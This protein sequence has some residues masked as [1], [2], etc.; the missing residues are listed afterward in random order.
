MAQDLRQFRLAELACSPCAT[1]E[2]GQPHVFVLSLHLSW[3]TFPAE[4][5]PDY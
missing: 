5:L 4:S 2:G 3:S 1:G